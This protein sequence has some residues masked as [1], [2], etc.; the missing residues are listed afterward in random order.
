MKIPVF[1]LTLKTHRRAKA[2][3]GKYSNY[4]YWVSIYHT[5]FSS[6]GDAC[7]GDRDKAYIQRA[8][9]IHAITIIAFTSFLNDG[10]YRLQTFRNDRPHLLS[11]T[12]QTPQLLDL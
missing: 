6:W 11:H 2:F 8:G 4:F 7:P 12:T 1:F 10:G 5:R 3:V 9:S